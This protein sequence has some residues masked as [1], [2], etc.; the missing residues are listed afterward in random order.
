V[1]SKIQLNLKCKYVIKIIIVY[2]YIIIHG[3]MVEFCSLLFKNKVVLNYK[4]FSEWFIKHACLFIYFN[5]AVFKICVRTSHY[6]WRI[7][8][9]ILENFCNYY[10]KRDLWRYKLLFF[11]MRIPFFNCKLF[12]KC[13]HIRI[14]VCMISF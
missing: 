13:W 2:D 5:N 3:T 10:L 7:Y 4:I 1:C 9:Q 12:W 11:Q 6:T 8:F 14:R